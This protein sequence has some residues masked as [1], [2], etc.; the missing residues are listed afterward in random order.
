M[1][2]LSV[3]RNS[4][5][6][7]MAC[8]GS[9]LLLGQSSAFAGKCYGLQCDDTCCENG[10]ICCNNT[11]CDSGTCCKE[12]DSDNAKETC[13]NGNECCTE[14]TNEDGSKHRE[15]D[16]CPDGSTCPSPDSCPSCP[17]ESD[18]GTCSENEEGCA[19]GSC[20]DKSSDSGKGEGCVASLSF[21]FQLGKAVD[22]TE[23]GYL[24]I[25]AV[26][27]SAQLFTSAGLKYSK[28]QGTPPAGVEVITDSGVIRQIKTPEV[29]A[30]VVTLTSTSYEIRFYDAANWGSKSGTYYVP[31]VGNEFVVWEVA[32]GSSINQA[33]ISKK[34]GGVCETLYQYDYTA[35][36][37]EWVLTWGACD[38]TSG[39]RIERSSV[40]DT[41]TLT[42]TDTIFKYEIISSQAYL[43]EQIVRTYQDL[44]WG[45]VLIRSESGVDT[46]TKDVATRAYYTDSTDTVRYKKLKSV[47]NRDGSWEM[48]DY[49]SQRRISVR[50]TGWKNTAMPQ[51]VSDSVGKATV[52]E[53]AAST[54]APYAHKPRVVTE[55]I[56]GTIVAKTYYT[57]VKDTSDSNS[58]NHRII[59][60]QETVASPTSGDDQGATGNLISRREYYLP[61]T[62]ENP[63]RRLAESIEPNGVTDLYTYESGT[64]TA[65]VASQPGTFTAGTGTDVRFTHTRQGVSGLVDGKSTR[66]V[67]VQTAAGRML[68]RQSLAYVSSAWSEVGWEVNVLDSRGRI[69]DVYRNNG[70]HVENGWTDCCGLAYSVNETGIRTE[71][72]YDAT[73]RVLTKTKK[74]IAASGSYPVQSDIIIGYTYGVTST[75]RTVQETTYDAGQTLSLTTTRQYDFAG[76][77]VSETN[78]AGLTTQ[79]TWSYATSGNRLV[80][81]VVP[82]GATRIETYYLDGDLQSLT[83]TAQVNEYHDRG[84]TSGQRWSTTYR[85]PNLQSS[86]NWATTTTDAL[87]RVVQEEQPG[88]NS[89][90]RISTYA[91]GTTA[92]ASYGKL[93]KR[94]STGQASM[95]YVYDDLGNLLR[96]GLDVA[97]TQDQLDLASEDRISETETTY[98]SDTTGLWRRT[99]ARR[100]GY[101]SDGSASDEPVT[102]SQRWQLLTGFITNEISRLVQVDAHG[103]E[104]VTSV[105]VDRDSNLVTTTA[106]VPGSDTNQVFV[107]RNG[108]VQSQAS[109]TGLTTTFVH[110]NLGRTTRITDAR[111]N[112][113]D[114]VYYTSGTGSTGQIQYTQDNAGSQTSYTY[115]SS[116][117]E[118]ASITTAAG[119][120]FAAYTL[121][122]ELYRLWGNTYPVEYGYDDYGRKTSMKTYRSDFD[123]SASTWPSTADETTWTFE[124]ATGLLTRKTYADGTHA[125]YTHTSA[126]KLYTRTWSRTVNSAALVTTYAYSTAGDLSSVSYSDGTTPSVSYTYNRLGKMATVSDAVGTRT[127][128]Y[129]ASTLEQLTESIDGS[130]GGLYSKLVTRV[131]EGSGETLPGRAKGLQ[132]GSSGDPDADYATSWAYDAK[133]RLNKILG[134][135]LDSTYGVVYD[136]LTASSMNTADVVEYTRFRSSSDADLAIVHRAYEATRNMADY[137]EN[138]VGTATV[139]KYDYTLDVLGRRTAVAMTGTAI[140]LGSGEHHWDY[141]YN[142]RS[143]LTGGN[144]RTGTTPDSGDDLSTKFDY[145]YAY[146]PIGNR[147]S[148][149][150]DNASPA[151]TYT[152]NDVNQY[153]ATA[154]PAESFGYDADG[155]LTAD[156]SMTYEWDGE[157]RLIAAYPTSPS[158]GS[159]KVVFDYDYMSRRVRKCV[160]AWDAGTTAWSTTASTDQRF[161]YD[162]WNV[163]LVLNGLSSNATVRGYTWGLDLSGQNGNTRVTGMHGAGGIGGLLAA[164]EPQTSGSAKRYW[165]LYDANGN[166]GQVLDA[167][168]AGAIT[169][170]AA[171]EYD[172]YGNTL[173]AAG[174]YAATNP[175]RFSTKWLDTGASL[176]YYGYR[177]YSP[178]L[179]RWMSRDPIGDL[180]P[181]EGV[182]TRGGNTVV[183]V[184][185]Y[186]FVMNSPL[187]AVDPDG[188]VL[189]LVVVAALITGGC[190]ILANIIR[191]NP[192]CTP[193]DMKSVPDNVV[194]Q[195]SEDCNSCSGGKKLRL[196][197][198]NHLIYCKDIQWPWPNEWVT[199]SSSCSA[200]LCGD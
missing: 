59:E 103:N 155:N 121:R 16:V 193:G 153:S 126:G 48:R 14:Y 61:G 117:G 113:T 98:E 23:A 137:V 161:V 129:D 64:Y 115:D 57:Y 191:M 106:D 97:G 54:T 184:P 24:K 158:S 114:T 84:V 45:Y 70:T 172:T 13:C 65:T 159:V 55:K 41:S 165:F 83:G 152:S 95:L 86:P 66:E 32:Q 134:P 185:L 118:R 143:E 68:Y 147:T 34:I 107:T 56:E 144:R 12:D 28:R 29:L 200:D 167:T 102:V 156:G 1:R 71:Y 96:T 50:L 7:T 38:G 4:S 133:G 157:N 51:T 194:C 60:T 72:T 189:Q 105:T 122:G 197:P 69:T 178:R 150:V 119:T 85:G 163:V 43:T 2:Y 192:G 6:V 93:T 175:F 190:A 131:Y 101:A 36:T 135:G 128:G 179:G 195:T 132:V 120:G 104:T 62:N 142:T 90:S 186:A 100:Y 88:Y 78:P 112:Y 26:E 22:A 39:K 52:Y 63:P 199:I 19:S 183:S 111:G 92:G 181:N 148:S 136:R 27:P 30:D 151:M 79:T 146:D 108:L 166:V 176:Y 116:T 160:Y 99:V 162:Q 8:L 17:E 53:Y 75:G 47:E 81:T 168:D 196:V 125:D 198:C 10:G 140:T 173:V 124:N 87:G 110:D 67:T 138:T 154:S 182:S 5:V 169:T 40:T 130:S 109:Q 3:L 180:Q 149:N 187:L 94:T 49:D 46:E 76:R 21:K 11:C 20:S 33:L 73:G 141:G 170:A 42:R 145:D 188:R 177:Y 15:C 123:G 174:S 37:N 82:G 31:S 58:A 9:L 18:N 35:N 44:G 171:Y 127:L 80:T 25:Y 74:G 89:T 77:L 164:E 139:S 91:Y